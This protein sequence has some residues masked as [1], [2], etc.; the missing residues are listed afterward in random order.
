MLPVLSSFFVVCPPYL[1]GGLIFNCRKFWHINFGTW[2]SKNLMPSRFS[3]SWKANGQIWRCARNT[4]ISL[5]SIILI[6]NP[7]N[8][9]VPCF[10]DKNVVRPQNMGPR[11][12]IEQICHSHPCLCKHTKICVL[13]TNT[14]LAGKYVLLG[15]QGP[16]FACIHVRRSTFIGYIG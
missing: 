16:Y 9:Y 13:C 8:W 4:K 1:G 11:L 3:S 2:A 14:V 15:A 12:P 7:Q 6:P 10:Y 5:A